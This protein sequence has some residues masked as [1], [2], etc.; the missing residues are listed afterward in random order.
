MN[1]V[2]QYPALVLNAD[3]APLRIWPL[4]TWDFERTF[5]NVL[6]RRVVVVAEYDAVLRSSHQEYRPPSVVALTSFVKV[7][8]R[9]AF[10]RMN[11]LL[12]DK[13]T[14]QYCGAPLNL[15]EMTF[16][17]VVPR[18]KGGG[19]TYENI[20]SC[21]TVCNMRKA[22][23]TDMRPQRKPVRPHARDLLKERPLLVENLHKTWVDCLYWSGVLEQE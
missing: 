6:K 7:P 16:D 23:R 12:R 14:C 1:S 17:H 15:K 4:S 18:A 3:Y 20:V 19:T 22:D 9:V 10:N 5:R 13:C 8:D 11:I 21:C 2:P